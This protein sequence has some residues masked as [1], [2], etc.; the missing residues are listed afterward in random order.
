MSPSSCASEGK[1]QTG[2]RGSARLSPGPPCLRR[3]CLTPGLGQRVKPKT[4]PGAHVTALLWPVGADPPW[5]V[6]S[7]PSTQAAP[8][9]ALGRELRLGPRRSEQ[10][11]S[12]GP[13][14]RRLPTAGTGER[15]VR[16]SVAPRKGPQRLC[17]PVCVSHALPALTP[18][19]SPVPAPL[20]QLIVRGGAQGPAALRA[21]PPRARSTAA[22]LEI[23]SLSLKG[24]G[25]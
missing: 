15:H 21:G 4:K 19:G 8:G 7:R 14:T 25:G 20:T 11:S 2:H 13:G 10:G 3:F 17:T 12:D 18:R 1:G 5:G 16:F 23:T 22:L 6:A 9:G 24:K